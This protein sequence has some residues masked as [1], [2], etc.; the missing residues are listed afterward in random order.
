MCANFIFLIWGKDEL[1]FYIELIEVIRFYSRVS[2]SLR[3]NSGYRIIIG[4]L[5][6][7]TGPDEPHTT[8][9]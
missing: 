2:L 3:K 9:G 4:H 1:K 7:T 6:R 5:I 8:Q